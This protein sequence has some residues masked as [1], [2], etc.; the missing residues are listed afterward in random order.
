MRV[1]YVPVT[2]KE[3][4]QHIQRGAGFHGT[5]YQ[6]GAGLGSLFRSLFRAILPVAKTAGRAIGKRALQAGAD[7]ASDMVA[8]KNLKQSMKTRG[9]SATADLLKQASNKMRGGRRRKGSKK[10]TTKRKQ[11]GGRLGTRSIKGKKKSRK[12]TIR[13]KVKTQLG[14]VR[15]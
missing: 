13:K 15:A 2:E 7:I 4:I 9:R 14:I 5:P 10:K 12:N 3:W 8:G 11:R 1:R 6:R